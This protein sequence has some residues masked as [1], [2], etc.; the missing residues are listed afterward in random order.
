MTVFRPCANCDTVDD[1]P[2]LQYQDGVNPD[3]SEK[4]LLFH[5]DC[6][7]K[8][9]RDDHPSPAYEAASAGKRGKDL[10]DVVTK[11]AAKIAKED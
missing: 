11:H 6:T 2:R 7:P 3:G 5:Y 10:V 9:I 8:Y 1:S 4:V